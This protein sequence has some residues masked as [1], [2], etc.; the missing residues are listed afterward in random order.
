MQTTELQAGSELDALIAE[1]VMGWC[2]CEY[3]YEMP[4]SD[5][6]T[7]RFH[8]CNGGQRSLAEFNPSEDIADA[9]QVVDKLKE[10]GFHVGLVDDF[11]GEMSWK[12]NIYATNE[13]PIVF[14]EWASTPEL[15]ICRAALKVKTG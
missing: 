7:H 12:L 14:N 8:G 13:L 2:W 4:L 6:E 5:M 9:W 10:Q 11:G 1:K 15:A 3:A